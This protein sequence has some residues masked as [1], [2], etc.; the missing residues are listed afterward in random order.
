[1]SPNTQKPVV[2]FSGEPHFETWQL[3]SGLVEVAHVYSLDHPRLGRQHVRTSRVVQ[4][5][6]DGS[7]ETLNT[8]YKPEAA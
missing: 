6:D 1:M 4:K 2:H 7:F 8:I 5:F 3:E